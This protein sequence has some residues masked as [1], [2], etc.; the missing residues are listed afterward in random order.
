MFGLWN[1]RIFCHTKPVMSE[2]RLHCSFCGREPHQV[3]KLISSPQER[4]GAYICDQCVRACLHILED[5]QKPRSGSAPEEPPK[6]VP[7]WL[8]RML[9]GDKKPN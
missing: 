8:A 4:A 6:V 2:E 9:G 5:D 7:I 1:D 3:A